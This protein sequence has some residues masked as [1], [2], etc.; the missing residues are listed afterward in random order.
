MTASTS[1]VPNHSPGT[2][3]TIAI[4]ELGIDEKVKEMNKTG[5]TMS[6]M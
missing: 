2:F 5:N 1:F 6:C 4:E 3:G